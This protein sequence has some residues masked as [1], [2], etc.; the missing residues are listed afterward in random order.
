MTEWWQYHMKFTDQSTINILSIM[1]SILNKKDFKRLCI[2]IWGIWKDRCNWV[3]SPS[4][5]HGKPISVVWGAWTD[6][7]F[8]D[9]NKAQNTINCNLQSL[10]I[11]YNPPVD[12][13]DPQDYTISVDVAF[14]NDTHS[15]VM[16]FAI[17]NPREVLRGVGFHRIN[18]PGSVLAMKVQAIYIGMSYRIEH[19]PGRKRV[20]S[21]SLEAI[22]SIYCK[23]KYKGV[24]ELI[25]QR[26]KRL[27]HE[28]SVT[29]VW[30]LK[31]ENNTLAH[32]LAKEALIYPP[33]LRLDGR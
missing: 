12:I 32:T 18:P 6:R 25:I 4:F 22:H 9:Y 28:S 21:D 13:D 5:S 33:S 27:I 3:H 10:V 20:L 15:Y 31:R 24:E 23:D 26:T 1:N 7:F 30:H 2:K 17:Y 29:G 19:F 11:R 16:G 8:Y 14:C